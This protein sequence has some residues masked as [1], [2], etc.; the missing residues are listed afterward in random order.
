M[1][2][3][4]R[5]CNF[6]I[7]FWKLKQSPNGLPAF[8]AAMKTSHESVPKTV[9]WKKIKKSEFLLTLLHTGWTSFFFTYFSRCTL[10]GSYTLLLENLFWA[11]PSVYSGF[12]KRASFYFHLLWAGRKIM[13]PIHSCAVHQFY[14][15]VWIHLPVKLL[16]QSF[17]FNFLWENRNFIRRKVSVVAL[18]TSF[19]SLRTFS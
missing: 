6:G 14:F 10:P 8:A 11:H 12:D 13:L 9:S 7:L 15:T 5:K 17:C 2:S 1:S 19:I 18:R 16:L 4:R 3:G